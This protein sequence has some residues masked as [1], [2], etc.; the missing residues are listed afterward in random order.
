M[1]LIWF[2]KFGS[3]KLTLEQAFQRL[4]EAGLTLRGSKCQIGMAH[5]TYRGHTFSRAGMSLG[6]STL[7]SMDETDGDKFQFVIIADNFCFFLYYLMVLVIINI[8]I[9]KFKWNTKDK[10]IRFIS[11]S[12][13]NPLLPALLA[14]KLQ[15]S[16]PSPCSSPP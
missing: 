7:I 5:V 2:V 14:P 4:R 12:L 9:N 10:N 16:H 13:L 11:S 1:R 15:T 6:R 8:A 3:V